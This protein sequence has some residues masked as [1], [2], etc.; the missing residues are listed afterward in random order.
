MKNQLVEISTKD[1]V[2]VIEQKKREVTQLVSTIAHGKTQLS[3][4]QVAALK[5]SESGEIDLDVMDAIQVA[6]GEL[7]DTFAEIQL[8]ASM[9]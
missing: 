7:R 1:A 8:N 4:I 3:L 5:M 6:A 2:A 9:D